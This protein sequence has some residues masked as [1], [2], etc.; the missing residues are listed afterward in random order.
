MT[1]ETLL[2]DLR[3]SETDPISGRVQLSFENPAGHV[4]GTGMLSFFLGKRPELKVSVERFEAE[5][6]YNRYLLAF[7][8]GKAVEQPGGTVF[9]MGGEERRF[10]TLSFDTEIG[11]FSASTG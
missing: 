5:A 1:F 11:Q 7:L 9:Q 6:P 4:E 2:C 8:D 3:G 10:T